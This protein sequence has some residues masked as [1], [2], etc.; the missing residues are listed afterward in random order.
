MENS[1]VDWGA[2][3][4]EIYPFFTGTGFL[5]KHPKSRWISGF[6]SPRGERVTKITIFW[7]DK[8]I[9]K[10]GWTE[11]KSH[12]TWLKRAPACSNL[13]SWTNKKH[14]DSKRCKAPFFL[15][16]G[17]FF[18]AFFG[19]FF[20]AGAEESISLGAGFDTSRKGFRGGDFGEK[21]I[22]WFEGKT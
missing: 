16:L 4:A 6:P 8:K 3:V 22:Q 15:T 7:D 10:H 2:Q 9:T 19:I 21:K 5:Y 14:M 1:P 18:M 20:R 11:K 12:P 17:D 13:P